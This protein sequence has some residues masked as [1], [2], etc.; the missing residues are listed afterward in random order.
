MGHT[1]PTIT[2]HFDRFQSQVGS[3][4]RALRRS[5]QNS[6]TELIG[7]IKQHLP[8]ASYTAHVLPSVMFLLS[9]LLEKHKQIKRHD[10]E[11]EL[12]R[13]EIKQEMQQV[14]EEFQIEKAKLRLEYFRRGVEYASREP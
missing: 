10:T 12:L 9:G 11:F 14:R 1:L 2:G 4:R 13:Q 6:L 8:A 5:D 3:F 7:E